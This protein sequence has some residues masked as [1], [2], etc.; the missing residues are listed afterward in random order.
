[1]ADTT[2]PG[3]FATG[4]H[5]SLP[6]ASAV[7]SGALYSCTTHSLVYQ[8]DGTA[9]TTWATLGGGGGGGA[10]GSR[11]GTTSIGASTE[12]STSTRVY[13]KKI[14]AP[15]EGVI[16]SVAAYLQ[17]RSSGGSSLAFRGGVWEDLSAVP[18][19]LL[20]AAAL[21]GTVLGPSTAFTS[22]HPRW[23]H[24][25]T[26]VYVAAAGDYWIG[27]QMFGTNYDIFYAT[28]GSDRV[29]STSGSDWIPDG[30]YYTQTNSTFDY[31]MYA[32]FLAF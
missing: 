22:A 19:K 8:S 7:G 16:L 23:F 9:W 25:P 24:S 26:G 27:G 3:L 13:T 18:G 30:M 32:V 11:P 15:G 21:E 17:P 2:L 14:T 31:S 20:G 4:D 1:M 10:T 28:S 6:A 12:Q 5:A 29:F